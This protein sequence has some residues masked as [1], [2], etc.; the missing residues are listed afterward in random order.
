M[1]ASPLFPLG[2]VHRVEPFPGLR[3]DAAVLVVGGLAMVV[4]LGT[5]VLVAAWAAT[6]VRMP[7]AAGRSE[8]PSRIA[9]ALGRVSAPLGVVQGARFA[10]QPSRQRAGAGT[11]TSIIGLVAAVA[12]IS[13]AFVFGANLRDLTR[14]VRYGQTWDAEIS[15]PGSGTLTP[16]RT[17]RTLATDA[18]DITFGT[19]D[20][21]RI[22]QQTVPAYGLE[23]GK[24]DTLPVAVVGRLA[25]SDREV[26]LGAHTLHEL[27]RSVGQTVTVAAANG[28]NEELRIVGETL[29]PS[30]NTND[31]ALAAD[32]GAALTTAGLDRIDPSV[33]NETD[34]VLVRFSLARFAEP[35]AR[36]VP[37][38]LATPSPVSRR[39]ETL[40]ATAMCRRRR[41]SSR[42][43]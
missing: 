41:W 21:L 33:R 27:H 24:G 17:Q 31:A 35:T 4:V 43:C 28:K 23:P 32:D 11:V 1:L 20:S 2:L 8:H 5:V 39:P 34:F 15:A 36:K 12:A 19:Y 10:F 29:L 9:A 6:P 16:T 3:V 42:C 38:R 22:D 37:D 14:P 25:Q 13:A 40:R 26:A 7:A 30:L 18:S